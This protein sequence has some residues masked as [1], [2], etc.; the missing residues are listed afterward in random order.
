[1][2]AW[3][4]DVAMQARSD[5]CEQRKISRF[6]HSVAC[7]RQTKSLAFIL[8]SVGASA[9]LLLL[10]CSGECIWPLFLT[11]GCHIYFLKLPGSF[12]WEEWESIITSLWKDF[13]PKMPNEWTQTNRCLKMHETIQNAWWNF[14]DAVHIGSSH[15]LCGNLIPVEAFR[16]GTVRHLNRS[17]K[18][19]YWQLP[20]S[21][22]R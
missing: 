1:M 7:T 19:E 5:T 2:W 8:L 14:S 17:G 12:Q 15:L 11:H 20:H 18:A 4:A 16:N 10:V 21:R 6:I 3:K 22:A 9:L 13:D